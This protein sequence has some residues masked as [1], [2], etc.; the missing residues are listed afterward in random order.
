[1]PLTF[2]VCGV[3][4][5]R[6]A[7]GD[8]AERDAGAG[9]HVA[10]GVLDQDDGGLATPAV[11][12]ATRLLVVPSGSSW[13]P[14]RHSPSRSAC[15]VIVEKFAVAE[16]V[17]VPIRVALNVLMTCPLASVEPLDGLNVF[18]VPVAERPTRD[19]GRTL[20]NPS[21]TVTVTVTAVPAPVEQLVLH[22]VMLPAIYPPWMS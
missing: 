21:R 9:L 11:I 20:E 16:T 3:A 1:M 17:W 14:P 18:T 4:P 7:A 15:C 2:V 5:D 12:R 19:P 8:R 22:A 10:E 13:P 6:A